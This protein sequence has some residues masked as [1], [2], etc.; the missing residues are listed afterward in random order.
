MGTKNQITDSKNSRF[1]M[2]KN[3]KNSNN[4]NSNSVQSTGQ[5]RFMNDQRK[6]QLQKKSTL[7]FIQE[8]QENPND[9]QSKN[10]ESKFNTE[11]KADS[12]P[13]LNRRKTMIDQ[14]RT[15]SLLTKTIT[16]KPSRKISN[17]SHNK[18]MLYSYHL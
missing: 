4:T 17:D 11:A 6:L 12:Q 7:L 13:A 1:F 2:K 5:R 10:I 16:M 8:N 9:P 18:S 14:Y 15:T 3:T